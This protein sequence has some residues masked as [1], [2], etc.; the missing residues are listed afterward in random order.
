MRI[1]LVTAALIALA[2]CQ[3]AA[4]KPVPWKSAA[5]EDPYAG[6]PPVAA[7]APRKY[8]AFSETAKSLTPGLLVL[9]PVQQS[10]ADLPPRATFA[11]ANGITYETT[12]MPGAAGQGEAGKF[13]DWESIYPHLSGAPIDPET[14]TMY[15]VDKVTVPAGSL[16][17]GLCDKASYLATYEMT[18]PG[19]EDVLI[20]A[21]SGDGWPPKDEA[22]LCGTFTYTK[23]Q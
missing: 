7:D 1:A 13:P 4:D 5:A 3:P 16:K 6:P 2:A 19:S 11:F 12:L 8:K 20:A 23:V 21:F 22:A 9:T 17:G 18:T 10:T 15:S 14:I